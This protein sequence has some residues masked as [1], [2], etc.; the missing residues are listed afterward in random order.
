MILKIEREAAVSQEKNPLLQ[1]SP[2]G[3]L[4]LCQQNGCM[5]PLITRIAQ[6]KQASHETK[7]VTSNQRRA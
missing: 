6:K 1:C 7:A 3:T 4:G 2:R 5:P